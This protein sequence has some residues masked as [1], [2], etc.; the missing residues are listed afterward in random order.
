M[1]L[2]RHGVGTYQETSTHSIRQGTLDHSRLSALSHFELILTQR[3]EL[4]CAS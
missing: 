2:S 1:P 3:M 4:V